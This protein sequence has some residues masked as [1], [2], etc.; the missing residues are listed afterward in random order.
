VKA[1]W[2][3]T[4]AEFGCGY[5]T[6]MLP[7]MRCTHGVVTALREDIKPQM[8]RQKREAQALFKV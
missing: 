5:G 2:K 3:T 6:F 1:V 4:M 8:V 7:A